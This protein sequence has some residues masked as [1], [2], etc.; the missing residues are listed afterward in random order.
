L[1]VVDGGAE[2]ADLPATAERA[3]VNGR[4]G[5]RDL[6]GELVGMGAEKD[7]FLG[8]GGACFVGGDEVVFVVWHG[9]DAGWD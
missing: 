4:D 9:K 5:E 7:L 3:L 6:G 2:V 1:E 8:G